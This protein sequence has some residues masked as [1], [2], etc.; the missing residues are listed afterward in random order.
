MNNRS[1]SYLVA[2]NDES[3]WNSKT[4]LEKC[5]IVISLLAV[6]LSV[7]LIIAIA[8]IE[9]KSSVSDKKTYEVCDSKI[10]R[11]I[12]DQLMSSINRSIDPCDNFYSYVCS[13]WMKSNA[14]PA[15]ES[16]WNSFDVLVHHVRDQLK[17]ILKEMNGTEKIMENKVVSLY[18]GCT[19]KVR[20][21]EIGVEPLNILAKELGGWPL[22][23]DQFYQSYDW[24]NALTWSLNE[25][26]YSVIIS[27]GV[28]ADAKNTTRNMIHL[29][30]GS[31]GIGRKELL[32]A[33]DEQSSRLI[34]A[35]KKLIEETA[36]LMSTSH[37][38]STLQ[39][40]IAEIIEFETKLAT[41]TR[42]EEER[43][44][45][46]TLY[47]KMS[48]YEFDNY[49]NGN[50]DLFT[51]LNGIFE[52]ITNI[53]KDMEIIVMEPECL[54]NISELLLTTDKRIIANYIGWRTINRYSSLTTKAFREKKFEFQKVDLGLEEMQS[55]EDFCISE[56]NFELNY[57]LGSIYINHTFDEDI[58]IEIE[59]MI[60]DLKDAFDS[61]LTLS[62]WMDADTKRKAKDKLRE[63]IPLIAYPTWIL[64]ENKLNEYYE[65]LGEINEDEF[66]QSVLN[67]DKFNTYK[68]LKMINERRNRRKDSWFDS[69]IEV[70]AYYNPEDNTIAFPAGILQFP[71]F[72]Y[73]IPSA[74]NY[75]AVGAVIGH[76]ITHGFDDEGSKYDEF[77]NLRD[78]WPPKIMETFHNKTECFVKQYSS[79]EDPTTHLKL[80]GRNT[81]G[82]N[83][84]DNGG[85]RA[86][87]KAYQLYLTKYGM[88]NNKILPKLNLSP[89][90][91]FFVG[92]SYIWC[93]NFRP[94]YLRNLIEYNPHSPSHFRVLGALTNNEY[95]YKAFNCNSNS[96]MF[97]ENKCVLW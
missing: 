54:S 27:V 28:A 18:R 56:V 17:R 44:I 84:A 43:R 36:I 1:Q 30:Y 59:R 78:W 62:D 39:K 8:V 13:G 16:S 75:G 66:F 72:K 50:M 3:F 61:F 24:K 63:M 11:D 57:A 93:S 51:I 23:G 42:P 68:K 97:S 9:N 91:L 15:T 89:E 74:L 38:N 88:E 4:T 79:Y 29:D 26:G 94:E 37:D 70:N 12:E 92:F 65:R 85:L 67:S 55:L 83:I 25:L 53:S 32:N 58:K 64:D 69:P 90:Q 22:L 60:E 73:G 48:I 5:L 77:G 82:E 76:E 6:V 49:T 95:F 34:T 33:S 14:L 31:L 10:C 52:G 47:H 35:Y 45:P 87:Y 19:N 80:N 86:A 21:E 81:L 40:E 96:K 46:Q 41:F 2:D 71:F 7:C 20:K